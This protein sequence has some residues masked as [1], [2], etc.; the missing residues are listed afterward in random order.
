M[1]TATK[2]DTLNY[3]KKFSSYKDFFIQSNDLIFS[4]LGLGTFSKE[5]YKEENYVFVVKTF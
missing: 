1:V 5:P 2:E 4:K 3:A